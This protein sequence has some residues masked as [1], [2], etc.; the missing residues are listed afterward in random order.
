MQH[1]TVVPTKVSDN[2]DDLLE[3]YRLGTICPDCGHELE[4]TMNVS[5]E[6]SSMP[7]GFMLACN[8]CNSDELGRPVAQIKHYLL[9]YTFPRD[10]VPIEHW[11]TVESIAREVHERHI[12]HPEII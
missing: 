6:N 5:L 11:K 7:V 10:V 2:A 3:F 1:Q 12:A 4:R 9:Q 8:H